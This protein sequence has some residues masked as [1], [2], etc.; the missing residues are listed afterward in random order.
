MVGLGNP[1]AEYADT[2]HNIGFAV[3]DDLARRAGGSFRQ[4]RRARAHVCEE[5][6]ADCRVVLAKPTTYMNAAGDAVAPLAAFYRVPLTQ[7]IAVHDDLDLPL[8]GLRLKLGGGDGGHN[9]LKSMRTSLKSGDFFRVR[10]GIG[11]PPGQMAPATY[12]LRRFAA[13]ERS[14]VA[15][16]VAEAADAVLA[17]LT[18]GLATAQNQF[19]R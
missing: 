10:V 6:L 5:R 2:R 8:G 12:V 14:E 7:I 15:V 11:R 18:E 13:A 4:H 17:L 1:G 9:G 19:N 3:V 16:V